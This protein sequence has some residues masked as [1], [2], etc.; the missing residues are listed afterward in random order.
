MMDGR[1]Q[2]YKLDREYKVTIQVNIPPKGVTWYV[3]EG[4]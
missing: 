2:E 1:P 4:P 3:V